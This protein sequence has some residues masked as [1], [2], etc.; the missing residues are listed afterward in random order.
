MLFDIVGIRNPA[1]RGLT[2]NESFSLVDQS[3]SFAQVTPP[4]ASSAAKIVS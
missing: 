4:D 1:E 3:I 2:V